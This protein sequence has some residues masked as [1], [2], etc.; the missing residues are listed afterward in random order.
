M[1]V[2]SAY[3]SES[4]TDTLGHGLIYEDSLPLRWREADEQAMVLERLNLRENNEATLRFLAALDEHPNENVDESEP[5]S[6]DLVRMETKLNLLLGLVGQLVAAHCPLPPLRT[7][8]L[9]PNGIEW[10]CDKALRPG[11]CGLVEIYL[12][13]YC[14]Q[15]LVFP[16]KVNHI[17][18]TKAGYR[19]NVQFVELCE[20]TRERLEKLI[21]RHHRRSV[22]IARRR[23]V[24]DPHFC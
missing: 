18:T 6:Q 22:A 11:E 7:I 15:P 9:N 10:I 2:K 20:A 4:D 23:L 12:S 17:E 1:I 14:P 16:G 19:I 8:K 21:F 24:P 5:R 13:T 3:M